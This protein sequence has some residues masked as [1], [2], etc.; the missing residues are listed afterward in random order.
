MF[1]YNNRRNP[2]FLALFGVDDKL[3]KKS[4]ENSLKTQILR[5][6]LIVLM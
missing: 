5:A 3:C 2:G 1:L 6:V 4:F